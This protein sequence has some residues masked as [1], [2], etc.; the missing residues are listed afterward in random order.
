MSSDALVGPLDFDPVVLKDK[1]TQERDRRI[2]PE[3]KGQYVGT[4]GRFA[5]FGADPWATKLVRDPITDHTNVIVAG[6]GFG[7]LLVGARLREAGFTDIRIIEVGSDFGGTWY[8]NRYPGAMCDI[9]AHIY[10][11]LLEELQY[12]PKHR[13]SY[14]GEMLEHSQRIGKAYDL[15]EKACFQTSITNAVWLEDEARWLITTDHGD[16]MTAD[17]FVPACG[18]Q[19]LPKL[20]SIPGIDLYQGHTFHSSRWDYDYT[21]GDS[22]GG[23]TKL[24]DKRIGIIGT[25]ATALQ[26]VPEV[27]K[28]A[29][30]LLVFQRTPSTVGVRAQCQTGPDWVDMSRPGWQQE[31]RDNFQAQ[32]HGERRDVDYVADGWTEIFAALAPETPEQ[33]AQRLGRT[34]T[35][36]E[37]AYLTEIN[38]YKVMNR[39]RAR[40]DEEVD[41]PATAEALKP[42]YRWWCKRPGFH[43]DYLAAFNR[44]N[45]TLVDTKGQG[46]ERF[47]E[48]GVVIAGTEYEVDCLIFATG[49]EAGISYT[50]LTGFEITGREGPLSEHWGAGVRTLHGL[51]TDGF[52]NLFFVGGNIQTAVAVNAVHLL[53]EQAKHLAFVLSEMRNRG[54]VTIE[55]N[56]ADIDAYVELIRTHP[57]NLANFEFY[58]QCTPGYYNGEG[59]A[60]K[61]EDLFSGGRYG[62]GALAYYELLRGLRAAR[63][64]DG[65]VLGHATEREAPGDRRHPEETHALS[66]VFV[67]GDI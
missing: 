62:D 41:D 57:K 16:S 56:S 35:T 51:S 12:A 2:R 33:V 28:Y 10:L 36:E 31:R 37:L 46:V 18:R 64:L 23:M 27:A 25:G 63:S 38:D 32:V 43:D 59:K 29:K 7:G 48:T 4:S 9:E 15:Y 34:P 24:A 60:S 5:H 53:D 22:S 65:F 67:G 39:L 54:A 30:E 8:W 66:G 44:P 20:P 42:W 61:L 14:A 58:A 11:P 45:V 50:H 3:G 6:G 49:F 21:G 55:P 26:V 19:S 52:P 47:T 1:Y 40:I 13:Y 17:F